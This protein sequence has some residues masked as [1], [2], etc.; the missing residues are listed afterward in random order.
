MEPRLDCK[1]RKMPTKKFIPSIFFAFA[2]SMML[3]SC[4]LPVA[5][6]MNVDRQIKLS[7][8]HFMMPYQIRHASNGDVI[9]F[10]STDEFDTRPWATR[11][12]AKGEVLW[13]L[14]VG[15]PNGPP[16]DRSVRG[17]RFYEAIDFD[18]R[19]TLLC[20]IRQ[21][22]NHATV[23]LDKVGADGA[24]ISEQLVRPTLE[25]GDKGW[26]AAVTCARWNGA[27]V[28]FGGI[29]GLPQGTAWFAA[30]NEKLEVQTEKFGLQFVTFELL[31]ATAGNLFSLTTDWSNPNEGVP[32]IVKFGKDGNIVARYALANGIEPHLVYPAAPHADLRLA[33][34]ETTL[35]TEIVDL[36][37]QLHERR[38]YKLR[39]AG[40]KKCLELSDGSIAIFGSVFHGNATAAVTRLYKDGTSQGFILQPQNQSPWF[41][42]AAY[43]GQGKQFVAVR[44]TID[45]AV[46]VDWISFQ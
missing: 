11:L 18:D 1:E 29:A 25:K 19:S 41:T 13:D 43:T 22:D 7:P 17:Q 39:N 14:V 28:L 40:I 6:R 16:I 27:I 8:G 44:T 42:D 4:A 30:L 32:S 37:N 23:F 34:L 5:E 45:L 15:G 26:I 12:S 2:I 33:L 35:R 38:K 36:D 3:D 10:G 24:L 21:V 46:L 31:N 9:V 20:G